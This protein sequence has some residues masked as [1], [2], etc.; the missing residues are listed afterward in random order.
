MGL[1]FINKDKIMKKL[2]NILAENMRRFNTKNLHE[3]DINDLQNKLG[4]DSGANRDPRN[5]NLKNSGKP[6]DN[7]IKIDGSEPY[8]TVTYN[9][10]GQTVAIDFN[11]YDLTDRIDNYSWDGYIIGTD[12]TGQ[13]WTVSAQAVDIGGGDYDWEIDWDTIE[14]DVKYDWNANKK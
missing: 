11:E 4:F 2:E 13:E 14:K 12:N 6:Q 5:G 8:V 9:D 10:N 3:Q 7:I 1:I